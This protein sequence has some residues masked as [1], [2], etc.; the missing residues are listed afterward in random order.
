MKR[1]TTSRHFSA[2]NHRV[3]PRRRDICGVTWRGTPH[4]SFPARDTIGHMIPLPFLPSAA[5]KL[6]PDRDRC[7][8][9]VR[10]CRPEETTIDTADRPAHLARA[11]RFLSRWAAL[12]PPCPAGRLSNPL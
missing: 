2:V 5:Q 7:P 4:T 3:T 12:P 11:G 9:D 1:T 6:C 8:G 10:R